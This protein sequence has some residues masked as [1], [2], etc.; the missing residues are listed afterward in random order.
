MKTLHRIL[1]GIAC[2]ALA[3]CDEI[4]PKLTGKITFII[5]DDTGKPL[6]DISARFGA[7]IGI[8]MTNGGFGHDVSEGRDVKT[9]STGQAVVEF[10][11]LSGNCGLGVHQNGYYATTKSIHLNRGPSRLEPWNPTIEITV[12]RILNPIAMYTKTINNSGKKRMPELGKM[13]A[14]D[15]ELGDW[16][17]P[18]GHGK[19]SDIRFRFN[20][21]SKAWN[22]NDLTMG[23]TTSNKCD[24]FVEF[25]APYAARTGDLR[26]DYSAPINGYVPTIEMEKIIRGEKIQVQD[27]Y[28][29]DRNF[30]FRVRTVLDEKGNIISAHY[31]KIYG[32]FKFGGDSGGALVWWGT[33]YFNPAPNDRNVEFDPKRNLLRSEDADSVQEP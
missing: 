12:K 14:Y 31:G 15:L 5:K 27:N 21:D 26:S 30:Y 10:S 11:G 25:I 7:Q 20:G 19:I 16:L 17:P 9:D 2:L 33:S 4:P 1:A 23:I 29:E 22:D 13:Y 28:N 3:S 8:D 6:S 32:D 18:I 24:G